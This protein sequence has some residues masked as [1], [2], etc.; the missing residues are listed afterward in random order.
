MMIRGY[1]IGARLIAIVVGVI[2]LVLV[3]GFTV[4][5]C[6]SRHNKAAQSRVERSQA[7]AASNSAADAIGTVA[8]SGESERASEDL[9][10]SNEQ[11][12]RSAQGA[13]DKVNPAVRD[14]GIAALCRRQTYRDDPKC[15]G[16][17]K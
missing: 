17:A 8:R 4:R 3:V 9:T 13:N 14:A 1:E 6:D 12:I 16:A 11:Q 7:E 10:R 2:A 5:S 15:K